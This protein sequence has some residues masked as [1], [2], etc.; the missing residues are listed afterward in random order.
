MVLIISKQRAASQ[1]LI[2]FGVVALSVILGTG[3]IN[4]SRGLWLSAYILYAFAAA[5]GVIMLLDYHGYKKY[6]NASLVV[7]INFFLSCITSVE[8]LDAGGYLFIIPTIF[9]L[10]FMLGNTREYKVEVI[11][12]FVI[13]VLSFALSI[14]FIPEK[15]NWQIIS[16]EIYSKMFTTN[17]IAVVVLCA[18]FAYI[19]IYF[20]RQVYERLVNERNKAK[21]Q[22]QMIREQNGYLREI[23]FMSSHTVRAPLSNIL[24]LAAL[25]RDVPNDPDTHALVMDG[26]QNSAKDLDNAIHHMVSKTGNLIRR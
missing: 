7:T 6:K 8:G 20:E 3:V 25:M 4:H 22:E 15:S 1:R 5:I 2:Y 21:H 16:N 26:I 23:A 13:S 9:A 11:G 18:V 12:Y 24:G 19:G 17:A 14:L 10:V